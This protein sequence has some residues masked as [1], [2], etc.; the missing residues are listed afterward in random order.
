MSSATSTPNTVTPPVV[1]KQQAQTQPT[2]FGY[3]IGA[4]NILFKQRLYDELDAFVDETDIDLKQNEQLKKQLQ[5]TTADIR[6]A[7]YILKNVNAS[8]SKEQVRISSSEHIQA[9]AKNGGTTPTLLSFKKTTQVSHDQSE[10][11]TKMGATSSKSSKQEQ[12]SASVDDLT[13]SSWEGSDDWIRLNFK[14]YASIVV[15]PYLEY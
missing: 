3:T 8:R 12:L 14:W 13:S 10:T 5:L 1:L 11:S 15:L 4:T 6:F 7:D 2:Q 9:V